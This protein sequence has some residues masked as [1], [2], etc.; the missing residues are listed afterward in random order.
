VIRQPRTRLHLVNRSLYQLRMN[1]GRLARLWSTLW[2]KLRPAPTSKLSS[3]VSLA[4][5][6]AL[7]AHAAPD[8]V[9]YDAALRALILRPG[10]LAQVRVDT[11]HFDSAGNLNVNCLLGCAAPAQFVDNTLYTVG[12]SSISVAGGLYSAVDPACTLLNACRLRVDASSNL[13][14]NC[15][16]GCSVSS[17]A[18]NAAF[19]AGTTPIGISGG[20]YS[21]APTNCTTGS[22]CAPQLTID[23]KLFVN[24]FQGTS[25]WVVSANGGSFAVTGT[26]WQATQPV[27]GSVSVSNFPSGFNVNNS[28]TV[29][30]GGAPWSVSQS[31]SPWGVSCTPANCSVN[32]NNFPATQPVSGTVSVGNFPTG[33]NVNNFPAVQPVSESTI[34]AALNSG[35]GSLPVVVKNPQTQVTVNNSPFQPI[36]VRRVNPEIVQ[37]YVNGVPTPVQLVEGQAAMAQSLPVAIAS[38]QSAIPVTGTVNASIPATVNTIANPPGLP[39]QPCNAVRTT[40]CQHF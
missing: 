22:A 9:A 35:N 40:N 36:P 15:V 14:V 6:F 20:W 24:A 38:D 3:L 30:Q 16:V 10:I 18:D 26:F 21:V 25:P 34:D 39:K 29:N 23:R 17:F 7:A 8:N 5:L 32:I 13:R 4:L 11:C 37:A 12:T 19:V 27:S 31:G 1:R 28:P 2:R 33:F